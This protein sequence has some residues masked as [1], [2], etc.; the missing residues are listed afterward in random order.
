[1]KGVKTTIPSEEEIF[2]MLLKRNETPPLAPSNPSDY[3][4]NK[5]SVESKRA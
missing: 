3:S 2:Q 4:I 5:N 1:M